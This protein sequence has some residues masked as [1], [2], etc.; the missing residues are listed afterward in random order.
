NRTEQMITQ[1]YRILLKDVNIT[2]IDKSDLNKGIEV[3][4]DSWGQE[5]VDNKGS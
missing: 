3:Y 2:F 5:I 4:W 1:V